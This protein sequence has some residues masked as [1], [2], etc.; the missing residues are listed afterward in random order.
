M[1]E[2][3]DKTLRTN[4][5]RYTAEE[6]AAAFLANDVIVLMKT[7]DGHEASANLYRKLVI[8]FRDRGK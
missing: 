5:L 7:I 2:A 1:S 3:T 8:L 6:R 4:K